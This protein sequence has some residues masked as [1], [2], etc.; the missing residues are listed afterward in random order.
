MLKKKSLE[1]TPENGS[2]SLYRNHH[3]VIRDRETYIII[4]S[5]ESLCEFIKYI[6]RI[7]TQ[8]INNKEGWVL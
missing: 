2:F 5:N 1:E 6:S 8:E 7:R 3:D 4:L